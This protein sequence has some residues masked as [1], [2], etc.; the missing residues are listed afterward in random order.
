[1]NSF[2]KQQNAVV[3]VLG[4]NDIQRMGFH[5]D[6]VEVVPNVMQLPH[7]REEVRGRSFFWYNTVDKMP[8]IGSNRQAAVPCFFLQIPGLCSVQP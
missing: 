5:S 2:L 7:H 3:I 6:L 8:Q 1:M 4:I